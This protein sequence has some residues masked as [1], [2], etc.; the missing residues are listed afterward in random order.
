MKKTYCLCKIN[1]E[2]DDFIYIFSQQIDV[3][4]TDYLVNNSDL[5]NYVILDIETTGLSPKYSEVILVGFIHYTNKNWNLTQLLCDHHNEE[6]ELLLELQKYFDDTKILITYNGHSFDLPFLNSRLKKW[7]IGFRFDTFM[8]FDLYR[9][10]RSGKK[11]LGLENYKLKTVEKFL[12][13]NRDDTIS[14]KE[15]VELFFQYEKSKNIE[16]R[17]KILLHNYEDIKFLIPTLSILE[18]IDPD[19]T[20]IYYPFIIYSKKFGN[21][22]LVK[23][24][25]LDSYINIILA[26]KSKID[27]LDDYNESYSL[28]I[29]EDSRNHK[30]TLI[31]ISLPIFTI[32]NDEDFKFIDIDTLPFINK[33][34]NKLIYRDQLNYMVGDKK[35]TTI[36]IV[37]LLE[38]FYLK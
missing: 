28:V 8:N 19:I 4:F 21:M 20:D 10:I 25:I 7:D 33:E 18:K 22:K 9:V 11:S 38:E 27:F 26:T 30:T 2:G 32:T 23:Y 1:S 16:I 24:E 29:K 17:N 36:K 12:G 6:K 3:T 5:C 15:S 34:F 31:N 35:N 14:G 37:N 13:I